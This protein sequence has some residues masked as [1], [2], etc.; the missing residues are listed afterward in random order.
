MMRLIFKY[1]VGVASI[2][3]DRDMVA[4]YADNIE[5]QRLLVEELEGLSIMVSVLY[6]IAV[7][8]LYKMYLLAY[9]TS[10]V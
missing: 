9:T 1:V 6:A 3:I 8:G 10:L 2:F 7:V 5:G 4:L